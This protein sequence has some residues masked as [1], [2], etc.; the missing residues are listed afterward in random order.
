MKEFHHVRDAI[1]DS[2]PKAPC[3]ARGEAPRDPSQTKAIREWAI[4]NGY[5]VT[6]RGRRSAE[7][8]EAFHNAR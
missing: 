3:K 8:Q 1:A 4:A 7:A 5:D 6:A 2:K